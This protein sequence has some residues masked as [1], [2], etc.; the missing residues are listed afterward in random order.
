MTSQGSSLVEVVA[1]NKVGRELVQCLGCQ[2]R[3]VTT[4]LRAVGATEF[5]EGNFPRGMTWSYSWKLA[6]GTAV[7]VW[8]GF[9]VTM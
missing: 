4:L 2:A 5:P 1:E 3:E 8:S 6:L 9:K 7:T